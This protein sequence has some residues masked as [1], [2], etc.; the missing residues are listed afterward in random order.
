MKG[1]KN[2]DEKF[3]AISF[4]VQMGRPLQSPRISRPATLPHRVDSS[5]SGGST[6]EQGVQLHPPSFSS[7]FLIPLSD[8]SLICT[9]P[10]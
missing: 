7:H 1:A 5:G 4:L 6:L 9:V 2:A 8:S 3:P 10:A